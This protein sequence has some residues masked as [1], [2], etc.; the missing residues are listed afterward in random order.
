MDAVALVVTV[1]VFVGFGYLVLRS[2]WLDG[3]WL[4]SELFR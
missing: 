2:L 3:P 1:R 4:N